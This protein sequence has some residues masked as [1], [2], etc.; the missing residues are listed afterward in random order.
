M[1]DLL[2]RLQDPHNRRLGFIVPVR[3]DALVRLFVLGGCF[4]E[5]DCVDLDAEFGVVEGGVEGECV[6]GGYVAGFGVFG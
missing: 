3:R 1:P 4:F 2:A 6:G 5:L